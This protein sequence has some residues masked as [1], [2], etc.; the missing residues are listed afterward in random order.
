MRELAQIGLQPAGAGYIAEKPFAGVVAQRQRFVE[1]VRMARDQLL[2]RA[3]ARLAGE[4]AGDEPHPALRQGDMK[5]PCLPVMPREARDLLA[6]RV[7][8]ERPA[9]AE[10]TMVREP[11]VIAVPEKLLRQRQVAEPPHQLVDPHLIVH[12]SPRTS[13]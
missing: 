12:G 1:Q 9:V 10:Q 11:Q 3:L 8:R 7:E 13:A 6:H 5:L 4:R 2:E